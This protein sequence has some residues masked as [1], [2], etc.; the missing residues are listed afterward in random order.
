VALGERLEMRNWNRPKS[1]V[2]LVVRQAGKGTAFVAELKV[3]DIGHQLFDLAKVCCLLSRGVPSG[4]LVCV[5]KHTRDFDRLPGGELFAAT[6]GET[7]THDLV[8]LIHRHEHEWRCHVGRQSPEPTSVPAVVST[9]AVCAGVEIKAYPGHSARAVEVSI[10]DPTAIPLA[11]GWPAAS[12][13]R[14]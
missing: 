8:D 7:R 11:N 6:E 3:W 12:A 5:A 10:V 2:D 9:T 13:N 14:P 4:F 1:Q